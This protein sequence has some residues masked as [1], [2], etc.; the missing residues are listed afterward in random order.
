M[1]S[2]SQQQPA[3]EPARGSAARVCWILI[4]GC[5]AL[6]LFSLGAWIA[7]PSDGLPFLEVLLPALGILGATARLRGWALPP[8]GVG[9]GGGP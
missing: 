1:S 7:Q 2:A 6:V 5:A 4:L 3:Y 9:G 8:K